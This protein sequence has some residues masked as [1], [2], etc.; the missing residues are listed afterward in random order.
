MTPRP[1]FVERLQQS[2]IICSEFDEGDDGQM[3]QHL[4]GLGGLC[5][6]AIS[7]EPCQHGKV[8]R[9]GIFDIAIG[10]VALPVITEEELTP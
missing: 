6:V 7:G 3:I 2:G 4:C 1:S 9:R 8:A 10:T 5:V